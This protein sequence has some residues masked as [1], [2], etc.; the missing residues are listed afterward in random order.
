IHDKDDCA[1][2]VDDPPI[3]HGASAKAIPLR[4]TKKKSMDKDDAGLSEGMLQARTK[5]C[6]TRGKGLVV[7]LNNY[8]DSREGSRIDEDNIRRTFGDFLH[9]VVLPPQHNL[10]RDGILNYLNVIKNK[11]KNDVAIN[12]SYSS[13]FVFFGSHGQK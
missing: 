3:T 6:Y 10:N 2:S 12:V 13:L 8:T 7:I 1:M 9:Y 11:I 5:N 4:A